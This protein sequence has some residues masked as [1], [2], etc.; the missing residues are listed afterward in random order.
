M[1][2]IIFLIINRISV[3]LIRHFGK[4]LLCHKG[5]SFSMS[6]F[7]THI[8][9]NSSFSAPKMRHLDKK[10]RHFAKKASFRHKSLI[11]QKKPSIYINELKTMFWRS[12]ELT[13]WL[14]FGKVIFFVEV[15]H[16]PRFWQSDV[17]KWCSCDEVPCTLIN[18]EFYIILS[19]QRNFYQ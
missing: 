11:Q 14:F 18:H 5:H 12:E 3:T 4:R 19:L 9:F 16:W 15:S 13:D 2:F 1:N 7:S 8:A 10:K 17:S 6:W